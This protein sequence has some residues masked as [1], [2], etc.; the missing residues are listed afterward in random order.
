M[1]S[2]FQILAD[3][4]IET[5]EMGSKYWQR[6]RNCY[7]WNVPFKMFDVHLKQFRAT[8]GNVNVCFPALDLRVNHKKGLLV[9]TKYCPAPCLVFDSIISRYLGKGCNIGQ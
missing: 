8:N 9:E 4:A 6:D 1:F 2:H 7:L 5:V 3:R